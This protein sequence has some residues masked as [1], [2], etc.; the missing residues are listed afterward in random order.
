MLKKKGPVIIIAAARSGTKMLR[1]VLSAS[2]EFAGYPYDA[3]YIWKYGNYSVKHDEIEPDSIDE[4]KKDKIRSFFLNICEKEGKPR[5]LEKSVPNSLRVSFVRSVFP[6]CRIIHLYRNGLDVAPDARL[7]WQD[8]ASSERIQSREDRARKLREFPVSMAWPYLI[9][10]MKSY[11]K[12]TLLRQAHVDSWGPRYKG[13]DHDVENKRLIEVCAIQW[14]RCV[15]HCCFELDNLENGR[16]YINVAYE[17]LISDPAGQ[18]E[19]VA[20]F[21]ELPDGEKVINRGKEVIRADFVQSWKDYLSRDEYDKISGILNGPQE[22]LDN[23][24]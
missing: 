10:Y 15:E 6:D 14:A 9:E 19:R 22:L 11:G 23:L 7:C 12:K 24:E 18:L 20:D 8:S 3:N 5:L 1:Y 16:D 13:I 17:K 21:L 4:G 2:D